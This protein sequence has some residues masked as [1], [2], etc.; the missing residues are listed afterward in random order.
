MTLRWTT[1][2]D[3][4]REREYSPSSCLPDGDY[5][6]HVAEY[7]RA[8]RSLTARAESPGATTSTWSS[9]WPNQPRPWATPSTSWLALSEIRRYR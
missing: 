7:R 5:E 2:T 8:S 1:M 6:P 3:V 9:T 4:D